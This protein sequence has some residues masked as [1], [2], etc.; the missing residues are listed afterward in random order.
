MPFSV[1]DSTGT[2]STGSAVLAAA[3]PGRCAAPPAPAISTCR[4]RSSA[5]P[6]Y[7]K[8]RSGVR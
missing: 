3:I 1:F 5:G 7:S 6:A 2:P 4:P 8:S